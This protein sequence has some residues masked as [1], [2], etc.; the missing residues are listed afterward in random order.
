MLIQ[1]V[2]YSMPSLHSCLLFFLDLCIMYFLFLL[3]R[4]SLCS[5]WNSLCRL[6]S[7]QAHRELFLSFSLSLS[8]PLS[9][10]LALSPSLPPF[11]SIFRVGGGG[12]TRIGRQISLPVVVSYHVVVLGFELRTFGRAVSALT[13]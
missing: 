8:P 3:D 1:H 12:H 2:L 5:S 7:P 10:S 6:G 4:V 13:R 11:L 9:L